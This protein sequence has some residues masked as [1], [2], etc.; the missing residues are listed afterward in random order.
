[1]KNKT[2]LGIAR[3]AGLYAGIPLIAAT[4]GAAVA[5]GT[6]Y[7][8]YNLKDHVVTDLDGRKAVYRYEDGRLKQVSGD[9]VSFGRVGVEVGRSVDTI[10]TGL[11]GAG[12]GAVFG[13]G[14]GA[15][16]G[17]KRNN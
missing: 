4:I 2:L 16:L 1:M 9:N 14:V 12:G 15:F 10:E 13:L 17:K 7:L 8:A 6:K 3:R 5:G 11:W